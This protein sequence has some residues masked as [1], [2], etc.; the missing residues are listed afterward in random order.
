MKN[1]TEEQ[2]DMFRENLHLV[3]ASTKLVMDK[4]SRA[5]YKDQHARA[6]AAPDP[7]AD[8]GGRV[9]ADDVPFCPVPA[10]C[11]EMEAA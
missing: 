7:S 3:C 9:E 2:T 1:L 11:S 6:Q 4:I 10:K 8:N 5:F